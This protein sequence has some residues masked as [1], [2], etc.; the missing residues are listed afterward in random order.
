M[1]SVCKRIGNSIEDSEHN[2]E[3]NDACQTA[4]CGA[5]AFLLIQLLHFF[6]CFL[7]VVC[8]FFSD[9]LLFFLSGLLISALERLPLLPCLFEAASALGTVGL[10]LGITARLGP[11]SRC[12]LMGLMFLGRVGGLTLIWAAQSVGKSPRG[13]LPLE[14]ITIG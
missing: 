7:A 11:V 12:V 3:R 14:K 8:V 1:E 10:S 9:F 6:V 2:K 13:A 4:A 5:D